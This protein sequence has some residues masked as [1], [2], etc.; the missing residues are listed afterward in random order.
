LLHEIFLCRDQLDEVVR[1]RQP[2][3]IKKRDSHTTIVG[4][5]TT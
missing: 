5:S 4:Q 2:P 3:V 1:K